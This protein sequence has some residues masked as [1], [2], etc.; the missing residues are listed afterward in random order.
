M[1]ISFIRSGSDTVTRTVGPNQTINGVPARKNGD[2]KVDE[3]LLGQIMI[4]VLLL[5]SILDI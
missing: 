2:K 1:K 4:L 5:C 3:V